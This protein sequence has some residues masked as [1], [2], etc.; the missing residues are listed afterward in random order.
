M[1]GMIIDNSTVYIMTSNF[2]RSALGGSSGSSGVRNREYG[3]ID[4]NQQDVQA[5]AAYLLP[6]THRVIAT[7]RASQPLSR[8]VCR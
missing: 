5:I 8:E 1:I 4:T 2:S 7:V 6:T 3:I